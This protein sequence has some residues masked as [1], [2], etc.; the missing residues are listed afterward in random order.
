[1]LGE[2]AGLASVGNAL[3]GD[4]IESGSRII[5]RKRPK[6]RREVPFARLSRC[7]AQLAQAL[8]DRPFALRFWDGSELAATRPAAPVFTVRSPPPS[9]TCCALPDSS[10]WDAPMPAAS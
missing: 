4:A 3:G 10:G 9:R 8:P 6:R 7:A 2:A 1:M 5:G